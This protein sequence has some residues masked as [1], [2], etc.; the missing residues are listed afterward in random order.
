LK[1]M[2][3]EGLRMVAIYHSHTHSRAYPSQTDLGRAFFPGTGE[4]NFPDTAY[5]IVSLI[6][7]KPELRAFMIGEKG[8][9]EVG[10]IEG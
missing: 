3:G 5:V 8:V 4:P 6:E 7:K 2:E 9:M 10:I 1:E